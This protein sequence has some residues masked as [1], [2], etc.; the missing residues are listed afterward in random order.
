MQARGG[1]D[2]HLL[3]GAV[4]A[5]LELAANIGLQSG[6]GGGD[7]SKFQFGLAAPHH[8]FGAGKDVFAA[9]DVLCSA[10]DSRHS[11]GE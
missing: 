10:F 3:Q 11:S 6:F 7:L 4:V 1:V 9:L 2:A 8:S 5:L